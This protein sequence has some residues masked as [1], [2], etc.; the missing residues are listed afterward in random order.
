V[1]CSDDG[2]ASF[3]IDFPIGAFLFKPFTIGQVDEILKKA[4]KL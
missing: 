3:N 2:S 4:V 1:V